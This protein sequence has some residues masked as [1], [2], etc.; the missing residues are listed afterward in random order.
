MKHPPS[1]QATNTPFKTINVVLNAGPVSVVMLGVASDDTFGLSLAV[2]SA[3]LYLSG[4]ESPSITSQVR[5]LLSSGDAQYIIIIC[6]RENTCTST[7]PLCMIQ[8][9]HLHRKLV[10]VVQVFQQSYAPYYVV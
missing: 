6:Y 2:V 4:H 1:V 3:D 10:L 8:I 7:A 5:P 9:D